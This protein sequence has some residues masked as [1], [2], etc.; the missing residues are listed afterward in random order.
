MAVLFAVIEIRVNLDR[1]SHNYI[2]EIYY[3]RTETFLDCDACYQ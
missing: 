2:M 3:C 1:L